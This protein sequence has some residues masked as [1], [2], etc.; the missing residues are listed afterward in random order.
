MSSL[1]QAPISQ[2]PIASEDSSGATLAT[3]LSNQVSSDE[4]IDSND[5]YN[6]HEI[7]LE[8]RE[9]DQPDEYAY[10]SDLVKTVPT[11]EIITFN[12]WSL[13]C[14]GAVNFVLPFI[15]GIMLGFGEILAHEIGFRYGFIGARVFPARRY[16]KK[17][18][19]KFI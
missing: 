12:L 9:E 19:S 13:L 6:I 11:G 1:P 17:E 7:I 10:D 2:T 14:K 8:G 5:L 15:N 4:L 18:E 3:L 16:T